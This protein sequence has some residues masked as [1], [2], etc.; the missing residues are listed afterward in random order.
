M[1]HN[2]DV[3]LRKAL[4]VVTFRSPGLDSE[5]FTVGHRFFKGKNTQEWS[6]DVAGANL[7][8]DDEDDE[9]VP[10][11]VKLETRYSSKTVSTMNLL[12]ERVIPYDLIMRLIEI[13]CFEHPYTKYSAAILVFLPGIA[14]IRRLNDLLAEH[15]RFSSSNDFVIYLLHSSISSENQAAVFDVPPPGIRK[16]VL[17]WQIFVVAIAADV[18]Y[19]SATNIAETGITIPDITCVIDSGKHKEMR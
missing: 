11:D 6:E 18:S 8:D 9:A 14:E 3:A 7:S 4:S 12:D 13:L 19:H 2:G 1:V 16:I 5:V 15:A 17:G 10:K